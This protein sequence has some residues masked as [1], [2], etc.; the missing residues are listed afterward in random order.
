MKLLGRRKPP[1]KKSHFEGKRAY[2]H[3]L[4]PNPPDGDG[5][6]SVV[7]FAAGGRD[8]GLNGRWP[9]I[10]IDCVFVNRMMPSGHQPPP[11][12]VTN[13]TNYP[14]ERQGPRLQGDDDSERGD[15]A[16]AVAEEPEL[17]GALSG[18]GGARQPRAGAGGALQPGG[19]GD[20]AGPMGGGLA[21]LDVCGSRALC[22]GRGPEQ[23]FFPVL[24]V[25]WLQRGSRLTDVPGVLF[26][27]Y[28]TLLT[29]TWQF[30][31]R[32]INIALHQKTKCTSFYVQNQSK[33]SSL[34][35]GE[36]SA[37]LKK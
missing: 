34:G 9:V 10:A 26:G 5:T 33:P 17:R 18:V 8:H 15:P 4:Q 13:P 32:N 23:Q 27:Y 14:R 20:G 19:E 30:L 6:D 16:R 24:L 31:L 28:V 37:F 21:P 3:H 7:G 2:D 25:A 11:P 12:R 1:I 36:S 35:G 29:A 22:P